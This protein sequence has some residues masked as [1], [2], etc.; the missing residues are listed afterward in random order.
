MRRPLKTGH[1]AASPSHAKKRAETSSPPGSY[2]LVDILL[3]PLLLSSP[4][5]SRIVALEVQLKGPKGVE[6]TL[7]RGSSSTTNSSSRRRRRPWPA[8]TQESRR[9]HV[10]APAWPPG[11]LESTSSTASGATPAPPSPPSP[12]TR[13]GHRQDSLDGLDTFAAATTHG[14]QISLAQ[15]DRVL[16]YAEGAERQAPGRP[17]RDGRRRRRL[18]RPAD[19]LRRHSRHGPLQGRRVWAPVTITPFDDEAHA[20]ALANDSIYGLAAAVFTL[21]AGTLWVNSSNDSEVHVPFG[22]VKQSGIGRELGEAALA[23]HTEIKAVHVDLGS[24]FKL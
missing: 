13:S 19:F 20:V 22:G 5:A 23:A 8:S 6:F 11:V 9:G 12:P 14:P 15:H 4:V 16:S 3:G 10:A 7:P 17:A 24:K 2:T 18:L 1:L 21:D